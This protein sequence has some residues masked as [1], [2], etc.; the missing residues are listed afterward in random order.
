LSVRGMTSSYLPGFLPVLPEREFR[1]LFFSSSLPAFDAADRSPSA[2]Y[3]FSQ[4]VNRF[5][6]GS[7]F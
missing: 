7:R 3:G 5:S 2:T 1:S 4:T 6:I